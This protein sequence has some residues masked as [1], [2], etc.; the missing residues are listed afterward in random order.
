MI[1]RR[2]LLA[3]AMAAPGSAAPAAGPLPQ[4]VTGRISYS[5]GKRLW[6]DVS[7]AGQGGFRFVIDTGAQVSGISQDLGRQLGL[8]IGR[9]MEVMGVS[10]SEEVDTFE[11]TDVVIGGA[12]RQKE[13]ALLG[14][15]HMAEDDGLLA[16]G[17]LT[18]F[19]SAIDI[20]RSEFRI[21][22]NGQ[23]DRQA[24]TRVAGHWSSTD[25]GVS[26]QLLVDAVIDG[27][28]AQLMVDTGASSGIFLGPRFM[29]RNKA[30]WAE[31]TTYE[32]THLRGTTGDLDARLVESKVTLGG[33]TFE[34]ET[35]TIASPA[36]YQASSH[37]GLVGMRF[38]ERYVFAFEAA[39]PALWLKPY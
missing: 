11:A 38:L 14:F 30:L 6:T 25:G 16:A 10:G 15:R 18:F 19:D 20:V 5:A 32:D 4:V 29:Q 13:M 37:D 36:A 23:T 31:K 17:V 22:P 2:L 9:S 3:A 39:K 34:R 26:R 24:F 12:F 8:K 27:R 28:K 21:Y 7:I 33:L 35:V 1:T